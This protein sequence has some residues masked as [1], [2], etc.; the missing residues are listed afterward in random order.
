MWG[1]LLDLLY[2]PAC[3]SCGRPG[4][5]VCVQCVRR[6]RPLRPPL[7]SRCGGPLGPR[8]SPTTRVPPDSVRL[9]QACRVRPPAF[10]RAWS[11]FVYEGPLRDAIWAF[12]YGG[13]RV[14]GRMLGQLM[15]ESV[16][17][18]ATAG[19][20]AVVPVPLHPSRLVTRGFNQ[21]A[22]LARPI[23]TRLQLPLLAHAVRRVRHEHSQATLDVRARRSA[24]RGA[25]G[26]GGEA[27]S[28]N[29]LLVDDVFSTGATVNACAAVLRA[30][31][32]ARVV[33]LTLARAALVGK[34]ERESPE[35]PRA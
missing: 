8:P 4:A 12:K 22:L 34:S 5:Q 25:F 29:V 23:A 30:S 6:F 21:A 26:R 10:D 7:C 15:A 33:V 14:L 13:H 16:P 9:C 19:L 28:G 2:P 31:G 32:A 20:T 11:L 27:M 3:V 35:R 24:V 1:R 17:A 18:Q